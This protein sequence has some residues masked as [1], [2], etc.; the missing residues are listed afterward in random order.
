MC[1]KCGNTF[2]LPHFGK[3]SKLLF[4]FSFFHS[5]KMIF[6]CAGFALGLDIACL[7]KRVFRQHGADKLVNKHCEKDYIGN[8]F[9]LGAE[10]QSFIGHSERNARLGKKGNSKVFNDMIVAFRCLCA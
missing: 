7:E 9:A 1:K 4:C 6:T 3:F 5:L 8:Y 2:W 10:L